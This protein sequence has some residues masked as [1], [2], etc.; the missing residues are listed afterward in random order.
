MEKKNLALEA[1]KKLLNDEI[2]SRSQSNVVETRQFSE[3]LEA[4]IARYHTNAI[5]TVEIL[6]ELINM[7]REIRESRKRG[8]EE[9]LSRDEIAFYDALAENKSAV[10][11]MGDKNLKVIAH[12]LLTSLKSNIT[13]DWM[14]RDSARAHLRRLVKRILR[15]NGYPPDHQNAA[16]QTVLQQAEALSASW[17]SA[18]F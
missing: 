2:K 10:D 1:L 3:R 15:E 16:V 13:V 8:D 5:S 17:S 12:E 11:V 4:A 9:G 18:A 14:H 6:Q 7:A